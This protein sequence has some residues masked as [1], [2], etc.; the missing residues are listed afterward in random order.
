MSL[1]VQKSRPLLDGRSVV[2]AIVVLLLGAGL[3]FA[4]GY[5]VKAH[6][7]TTKTTATSKPATSKPAA[8][9]AS[10]ATVQEGI[11]GF[12]ACLSSH[13]VNYPQTSHTEDALDK[14]TSSPPSGVSQATYE[15][16]LKKCFAKGL[17]GAAAAEH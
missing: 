2:I 7:T 8:A 1:V 9:T 13:G 4:V 15:L 10:A 17:R 6:R 12:Y 3:G 14:Q 5:E 16:A 11:N